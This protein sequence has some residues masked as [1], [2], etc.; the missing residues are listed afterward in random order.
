M[1]SMYVYNV[2]E[3]NRT[4]WVYCFEVKKQ[5]IFNISPKYFFA[6]A[7]TILSMYHSL[8]NID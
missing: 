2:Q 5:S 6:D 4:K 3:N 1:I 8:V 7:L